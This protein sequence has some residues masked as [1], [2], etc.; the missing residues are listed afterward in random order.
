MQQRVQIGKNF[1]S[2]P[3]WKRRVGVTFVY[4]PLLITVPF[5]II[6]ILLV[7]VHL[8][9]IGAK[10]VKPFR[11]FVPSWSSHRYTYDNQIV[12]EDKDK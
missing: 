3:T 10:E 9:L 2:Q 8:K 7:K 6:G 11:D 12:Y 4:I 1:D 5:V